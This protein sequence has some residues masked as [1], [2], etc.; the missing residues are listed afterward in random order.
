MLH[1][2]SAS[3]IA[4]L[5]VGALVWG[6]IFWTVTFHRKKSDEIPKQFKYWF[7]LEFFYS[8]VPL[9]IVAV[10]FY[11]TAVTENY[12]TDESKKPDVNVTALAFKWNWKFEYDDVQ[13]SV[14]GGAVNTVGTSN[15]IPILVLPIDKKIRIHEE[16]ADVIH[17]FWVPKLLFKRDVIP[18]LHNSF[19]VTITQ[20]GAYVGHCAELCGTYHSAMNFELRTVGWSDYQKYVHTLA[21]LDPGDADRQ[22]EALQAIGQPTKAITTHPLDTNRTAHTG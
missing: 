17:S 1:L 7:A 20:K 12:V 22:V 19:Q 4:A 2:W 18:G 8:A 15:S 13:S 21:K 5:A 14:T 9:V 3:C 11:F 10:L 16:S 6:L